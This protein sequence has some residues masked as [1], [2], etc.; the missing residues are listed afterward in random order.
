M[1]AA[2]VARGSFRP[3]PA[4][5]R[6]APTLVP[7]PAARPP[8]VLFL[9][10][11][12]R[13]LSVAG[14]TGSDPQLARPM[15]SVRLERALSGRES[16]ADL[17]SK[18]HLMRSFSAA[19]PARRDGARSLLC[20]AP[21]RLAPRFGDRIGLLGHDLGL[22]GCSPGA[23][24]ASWVCPRRSLST[25]SKVPRATEPAA[26]PS[27]DQRKI[28]DM[29]FVDRDE[30]AFELAMHNIENAFYA[31]KK[32]GMKPTLVSSSQLFGAGKSAM[33]ANAVARVRG[34]KELRERLVTSLKPSLSIDHQ[35]AVQ[36]VEDYANAVTVVIDLGQQF[37][38]QHARTLGAL[39]ARQLHS[40]L[41]QQVQDKNAWAKL[42]P[43]VTSSE[44][45]LHE[46]HKQ[47]SRNVFIHFDE[48][49]KL[50]CHTIVTCVCVSC[51]SV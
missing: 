1:R 16:L 42:D 6:P 29:P 40:A 34:S 44:A 21:M 24:H 47:I 27:I 38:T 39:L 31:G 20:G 46:F 7:S 9:E 23:A 32:K 13:S 12:F 30:E 18:V 11:S 33:G 10:S 36:L 51:V 15:F 14:D 22:P 25:A 17:A 28:V 2:R 26:L 5:A 48:V 4:S 41:E 3:A 43:L 35:T 49:R 45:L 19:S 8:A 37:G 50:D